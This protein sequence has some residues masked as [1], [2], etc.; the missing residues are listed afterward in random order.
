[1]ELLSILQVGEW[2][3]GRIR[4]RK[5]LLAVEDNF[6]DALLLR[7]ELDT[8]NIRY[9][10]VGSAEEAIGILRKSCFSAALIDIGLP[11]MNG[12]DLAKKIQ[13]DYPKTRIF[14]MTGSSFVNLTESQLISIIRKPITAH[15]LRQLLL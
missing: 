9:A 15:S 12:S 8:L 1:M 3:M 2:I 11:A 14:F 10:I 7:E 5:L 13:D 4:P 6:R